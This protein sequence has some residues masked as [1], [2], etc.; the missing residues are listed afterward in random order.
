MNS[1]NAEDAK[2]AAKGGLV[3]LLGAIAQALMPV[4]HM[5]AARMFGQVAFGIYSSAMAVVDVLAR[6]G[7][8][9][10]DK[11][12]LRFIAS[13]RA[14]GNPAKEQQAFGTAVRLCLGISALLFLLTVLLAPMVGKVLARPYLYIALPFMAPAIVAA[15]L[16]LLLVA[17]TLSRKVTRVSFVMR[18]FV[19]PGVLM[20]VAAFMVV[21]GARENGL[22]V[23]HGLGYVLIAL[24]AILGTATVFGWQWLR[25]AMGQP[26]YSG[27]YAFA[28]PI[29]GSEIANGFYQRTDML[30]LPMFMPAEQVAAY[31]AGEFLGRIAANVRYAFDGITGPV[32]SEILAL[33]D[34]ERLRY[35]FRLYSRWIAILSIPLAVT[36]IAL[37]AD[38]LS[39]Y[40]PGYVI[41]G[42]VV[43]LH[44]IGHLLSGMLGL[45]GQVIMMSGRS[46]LMLILQLGGAGL[47]L[48]LCL[49]FIPRLGI[50]G[51]AAS[52]LL[53]MIVVMMT[54]VIVVAR[55]EGIH[56]FY[57]GVA[58]PVLAGMVALVVQILVAHAFN[59]VAARVGFAIALGLVVYVAILALLGIGPEEKA[60]IGKVW[61]RVF[62]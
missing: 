24:V 38:F 49:V 40:G 35:N 10:G 6:L 39:L 44:T 55:T 34:P 17:A 43:I 16:M 61:A 33:N 21:V 1:R 47:N 46:R 23:G 25:Q 19:E 7:L 9:G 32:L 5:L 18:G 13:E 48:A 37:R 58:K 45:A 42:T 56:A 30:V 14:A 27:F 15:P 8:A 50:V 12:V 59:N 52:V 53:S 29:A 22:W 28:L 11:A 60:I 41:A 62:R 51:A 3:Q 20:I 31:F 57:S 4:Y 26:R 36:V 2:H 54:M